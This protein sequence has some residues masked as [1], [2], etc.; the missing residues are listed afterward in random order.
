MYNNHVMGLKPDNHHD[1]SVNSGVSMNH[2]NYGGKR[3]N[4]ARKYPISGTYEMAQVSYD[5][6]TT[7]NQTPT[8][9]SSYLLPPGSAP[10]P[11]PM[12]AVVDANSV[13][14]QPPLQ[15]M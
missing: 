2:N 12:G 15:R 11:I 1:M 14:L 3:R 5:N 8:T 9:N 7:M 4:S 10:P 6:N 13:G